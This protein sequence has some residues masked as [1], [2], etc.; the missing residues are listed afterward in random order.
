MP[1]LVLSPSGAVRA[2][3]SLPAKSRVL[4]VGPSWVV[5]VLQDADDVERVAVTEW[6][7][8]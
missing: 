2:R 7:V 4:S 5:S 1:Y 8:P 3:V 6:R